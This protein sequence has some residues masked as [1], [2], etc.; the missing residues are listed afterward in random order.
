MNRDD[1]RHWKGGIFYFN[2]DDPD[3][4]VPKRGIGG[5]TLNY[6][7]PMAWLITVGGPVVM[8]AIAYVAKH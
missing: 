7:R 1:D 2:P 8:A 3:L 4:V 5:R 6:A